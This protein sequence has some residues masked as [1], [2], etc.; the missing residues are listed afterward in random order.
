MDTAYNGQEAIE[1]VKKG[2]DDNEYSY[3]LIFMDCSM[4]IMNGYV[5]TELIRDFVSKN[6][7]LQPMIVATTGHTENYYLNKCWVY[8][9]DEVVSKPVNVAIVKKVLN[10]IILQE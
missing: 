7:I 1:L 6:K 8:Q 5:A 3:G 4:P 10:D 2:F 9:I